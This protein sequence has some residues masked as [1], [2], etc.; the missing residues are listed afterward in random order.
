[1]LDS[2]FAKEKME[3]QENLDRKKQAVKLPALYGKIIL[4]L[5]LAKQKLASCTC[6]DVQT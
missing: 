2:A 6:Q 3:N 4:R 5:L 1:M